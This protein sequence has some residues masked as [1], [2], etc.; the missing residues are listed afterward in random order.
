MDWV[1]AYFIQITG[2]VTTQP[3]SATAVTGP[4]ATT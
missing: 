2:G 1:L 3:R 4:K